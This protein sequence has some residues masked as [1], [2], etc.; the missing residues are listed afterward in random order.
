[1][2]RICTQCARLRLNPKSATPLLFVPGS[3]I[4][5]GISTSGVRY[6]EGTQFCFLDH[7]DNDMS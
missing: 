5:R 7:T 6:D 2:E 1:M 4:T 3:A